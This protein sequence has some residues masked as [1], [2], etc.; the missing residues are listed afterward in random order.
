MNT[1]GWLRER[2]N[3]TSLH[4]MSVPFVLRGAVKGPKSWSHKSWLKIENQNPLKSCY[5]HAGSSSLEVLNWIATGGEVIQVSRMYVYLM[6]QRVDGIRGDE[7]ATIEGGIRSLKKDGG[8]L[9]D[10][11]RYTGRY[12]SD[13]PNGCITEGR[14]HLLKNATKMTTVEQ[15]D[16]Y[17][18]SGTGVILMG[19]DCD[20]SVMNCGADGVI[21]RPHG[22]SYG[23]HALCLIAIDEDGNYEGPGS[24]GEQYAAQGW[25]TWTRQRMQQV[26]RDP[27][28][29]VW[30]ISDFQY[31]EQREVSYSGVMG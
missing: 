25:T 29:E 10:S 5:G 8:C 6:G 24:W 22:Q 27:Q 20:D 15:M 19:I 3:R 11:L 28:Q 21:D 17:L 1:T 26:C 9:E 23:G 18:R 14:K 16:A 4:Q 7:G 2:E 31:G 30:G 12:F 13:V